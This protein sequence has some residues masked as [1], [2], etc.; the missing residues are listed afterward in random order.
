[1]NR[2]WKIGQLAAMTGIT[3]RT[4]R[5]Y[6]ELGLL[7]PARVTEAGHRLYDADSMTTL[8]RIMALKDIGMSLHEIAELNAGRDVDIR[9]LL[10]AH[11]ARLEEEITHRQRL[12]SKLLQVKRVLS[13][14]GIATA[15]DFQAILAYI[16]SIAPG[17][18]GAEAGSLP[19]DLLDQLQRRHSDARAH[20]DLASRWVEF[21]VKL[22]RCHEEQLPKTHPDAVACVQYWHQ[23]TRQYIGDDSQLEDA[24]FRFHAVRDRGQLNYGLTDE[25][26][27]YLRSL[28]N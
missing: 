23:F 24:V 17:K 25:L 5:Y 18:P 28:L 2:H 7:K 22:T 9:A 12:M 15:E 1:M 13:D 4:V 26:Y 14:R 21:I 8:Y 16:H 10:D 6:D 11:L 20:T 19:R 3:V 27:A